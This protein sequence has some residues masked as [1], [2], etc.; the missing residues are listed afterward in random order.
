MIAGYGPQ[1]VKTSQRRREAH[2]FVEQLIEADDD[3]TMSVLSVELK[4]V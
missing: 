1:T 4:A 2:A 3:H